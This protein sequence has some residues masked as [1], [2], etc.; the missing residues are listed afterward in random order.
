MNEVRRGACA[1]RHKNAPEIERR[2]CHKLEIAMLAADALELRCE[3]VDHRDEEIAV[4]VRVQL[5]EVKPQ[6][7]S[8][9]GNAVFL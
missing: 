8:E 6:N 1:G 2:A 9:T 7:S 5:F 3:L 4:A